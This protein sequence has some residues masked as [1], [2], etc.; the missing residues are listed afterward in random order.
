MFETHTDAPDGV[1]DSQAA[2]ESRPRASEYVVVARRYRPQTFDELVGQE[3]VARALADAITSRRVGHAY[4]FTGARGVGKTS[5]ARILAKALNCEDGPT[6]TPCNQCDICQSISRRRRRGR[7]GDRRRQQPRHRRDPPV[8]AERQ[9]AAQPGAV[10]DLHHRRSPHAHARGLQRPAEDA[11]RAARARQVHLLHDRADEDPDHDPLALPAVRFRGHSDRRRSPSGCGRSS[12]AEGV[13]AEPEALEVLARRAAGSMRDSQS[14]LEQLLAV[15]RRADHRGR[16]ARDAGHGRAKSGWRQLVGTSGRARRGGALADLDA[17]VA[18]GVDVGQLLEQLLRLPPRL[19]GG[20]RRLPGR[21]RCCTSPPAQIAGGAAGGQAAW[22]GDDA[23]GD[24]DSRSD[25]LAAAL[26]HAG[27][28]SWPS[29]RWCGSASW[30]TSTSCPTL[31]A[32]LQLGGAAA[33][34]RRQ[35]GAA[36]SAAGSSRPAT[37][38]GAKKKAEPP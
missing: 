12:Q 37:P 2:A 4:L 26:Q 23:G 16:R 5:A 33:G 17:A 31:I 18:E 19:H 21:E 3:H 32:Q 36:D 7:A 30:R 13:E 9:R 22:A 8:A 35:S 25:A 14:L 20:G 15:R 28:A 29:W 24:A 1:N 27:R 6:P 10:Q 11:G 34:M 38:V